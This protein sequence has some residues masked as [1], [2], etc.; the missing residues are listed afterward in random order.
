MD[1]ERTVDLPAPPAEVWDVLTDR[2][3]L[4]HW[5]GAESV[6]IELEPGGRAH[7]ALPD[8]SARDA[9]IQVVEPGRRLRWRWWPS[10]DPADASTVD[11]HIE[12]LHDGSRLTATE[13]A[14]ASA[15]DDAPARPMGFVLAGR[16]A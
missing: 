15:A 8:G 6:E 5:V 4:A 12:P 1:V 10:E 2:S 9:V 13:V 14:F 7:F 11:L 3:T 16:S